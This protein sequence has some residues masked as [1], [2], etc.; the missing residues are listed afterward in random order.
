MRLNFLSVIVFVVASSP[1]EW[2]VHS[3]RPLGL[4]RLLRRAN[5]IFVALQV[6]WLLL[7]IGKAIEHYKERSFH[8]AEG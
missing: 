8:N 2:Q 6:G 5:E 7:A 3:G 1:K 4:S